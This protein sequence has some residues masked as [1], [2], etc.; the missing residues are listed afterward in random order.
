MST[1][2]IQW[3]IGWLRVMPWTILL[4]CSNRSVNRP[5]NEKWATCKEETSSGLITNCD[6]DNFVCC[7][8]AIFDSNSDKIEKHNKG[9]SKFKMAVNEFA[10]MLSWAELI[11]CCLFQNFNHYNCFCKNCVSVILWR[12]TTWRETVLRCTMHVALK[13]FSQLSC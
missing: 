13:Q 4:L 5:P 12:G 10:D 8:R 2:C 11:M 1:E 3:H 6:A 9:N 7:R